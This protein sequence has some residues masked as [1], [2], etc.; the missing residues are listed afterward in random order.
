MIQAGGA[1]LYKKYPNSPY[2]SVLSMF[3]QKEYQELTCNLSHIHLVL[4]VNWKILKNKTKFVNDFCRYSLMDI[5]CPSE[6]QILIDD[7]TFNTMED[8]TDMIN[9]A[10]SFLRHVCNLQ[11][12]MR[13]ADGSFK[14]RKL[15]NL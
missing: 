15:N 2:K 7:G 10:K 4:E 9:D 3:V 13:M 8:W 12:Q 1:V 14:Y 11:C 5:V 6:V